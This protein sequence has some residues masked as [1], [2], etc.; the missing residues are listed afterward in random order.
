MQ[1]DPERIRRALLIAAQIVARDGEAFLPVFVRLEQE[2]ALQ[3]E[4]NAALKRALALAADESQGGDQS[5]M[6]SNAIRRPS[7]AP[8]SP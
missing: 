4:R 6:R 2:V 5:A 1:N 8:P 3:E 7:N